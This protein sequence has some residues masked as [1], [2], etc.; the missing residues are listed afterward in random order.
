MARMYYW[1][2]PEQRRAFKE[3]WESVIRA[4]NDW[5]FSSRYELL[6]TKR[7]L[8]DEIACL[9]KL[10]FAAYSAMKLLKKQLETCP[11]PPFNCED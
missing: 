10:S 4:A 2:Y 7:T 1:L 6:D 11:D 3:K 5:Y 9:E 8:E